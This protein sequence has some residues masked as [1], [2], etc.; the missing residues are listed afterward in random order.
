[1]PYKT[2]I[3][4]TRLFVSKY[5]PVTRCFVKGHITAVSK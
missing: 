5:E 2:M 4:L 3:M 1:M